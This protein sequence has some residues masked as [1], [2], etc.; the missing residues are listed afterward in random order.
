MKQRSKLRKLLSCLLALLMIV[1]VV[2]VVNVSAEETDSTTEDGLVYE[3]NNEMVTI[4]G[5]TGSATEISIPSEIDGYPVTNIGHNAFSNC[6]EIGIES[7]TIPSTVISIG[8]GAFEYSTVKNL[9]LSEGIENIGDFAFSYCRSIESIK[10]PSSIKKI[11]YGAFWG[12]DNL[13]NITISEGVTN[14]SYGAFR[15][16]R[17]I[18][19]IILPSTITNIENEAFL[20]VVIFMK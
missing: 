15:N 20:V 10:I 16:C 3:I 8:D 13:T 5:Y 7:I 11:G 19:K 6:Y 12:C 2:P 4:T 9:I 14:I 18:E 17:N 1:S